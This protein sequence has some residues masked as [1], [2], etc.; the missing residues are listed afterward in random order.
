MVVIALVIRIPPASIIQYSASV[1]LVTHRLDDEIHCL[2][3]TCVIASAPIVWVVG[4]SVS[5]G[6]HP[7]YC[8][9]GWH[10]LQTLDDVMA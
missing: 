10:V 9:R 5:S 8:A 2:R 1:V 6:Y 7:V 4:M 3:V